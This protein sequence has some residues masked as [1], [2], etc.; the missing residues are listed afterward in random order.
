MIELKYDDK[1]LIPAI[2]QDVKTKKVLMLAYMNEESLRKTMSTETTWFYSRSRQEL[3]NKGATS[4]N[5]QTVKKIS[6][7]CDGDTLL[8]EVEQQGAACHTG[9]YSCFYREI[10]NR[11]KEDEETTNIV[12]KLAQTIRDRKMNP[13][14]GSY[15]NYLFEKGIDKILKKIGEEAA[16]IIIAAKN[17]LNEELVYEVCDFVYHLMVLMEIRDISIDDIIGELSKRYK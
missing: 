17:P 4:G 8:I 2:V 12:F 15:T 13:K 6:Y 16:E 7:D 1:G 5:V 11:V 9:N 14:D 10:L 3:W